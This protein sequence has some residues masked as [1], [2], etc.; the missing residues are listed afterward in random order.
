[1]ATNRP[2]LPS[3]RSGGATPAGAG[4]GS[5][6]GALAAAPE[7]AMVVALIGAAGLVEVAR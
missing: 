6:G 7:W 2:A 3:Q 4:A 1:M 5:G